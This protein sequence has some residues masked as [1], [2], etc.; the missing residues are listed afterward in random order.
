VSSE[1]L[2]KQVTRQE[3]ESLLTSTVL[4]MVR[5]M[6]SRYA[7]R[8]NLP[9]DD[10]VQVGA[11]Q[12]WLA[13][14]RFDPGLGLQLRTFLQHRIIGAFLDYSRT[15][16]NAAGWRSRKQARPQPQSIEFINRWGKDDEIT[17]V[18]H[19]QP[20]DLEGFEHWLHCLSSRERVVLRLYFVEGWTLK[21]ISEGVGASESRVCQIMQRSIDVLRIKHG[22]EINS[23]LR[24][25]IGQQKRRCAA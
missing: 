22:V 17:L 7:R 16:G 11:M 9:F 10:L 18:D 1:D 21:E 20:L 6:A 2:R 14:P 15:T 24:Q 23:T 3:A 13:I 8:T 25:A 4:P 12:A 19:R 5:G